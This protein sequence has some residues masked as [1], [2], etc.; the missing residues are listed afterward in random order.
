MKQLHN[1]NL[2][3]LVGGQSTGDSFAAGFC[4]GAEIA[5]MI[6]PNPVT[7]VVTIG[8]LGYGLFKLF[9]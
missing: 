1:E 2:I 3:A 9:W 5:T 4:L 7:G 8:C 6:A